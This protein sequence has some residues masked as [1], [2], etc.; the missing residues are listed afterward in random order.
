[1]EPV[2]PAA[3]HTGVHRATL[4]LLPTR[5]LIHIHICPI[6]HAVVGERHSGIHLTLTTMSS[7]L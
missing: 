2:T 4:L 6:T 3:V 1:M 7:C 5:F